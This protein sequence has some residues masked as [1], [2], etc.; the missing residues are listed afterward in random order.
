MYFVKA[1]FLLRKRYP[2]LI[3]NM[4][5]QEKSLYITFDDG[6][7]PIV[8]NEIRNVLRSYQ[9]KATFFCVGDNI[10]KNRDSFD[11]LLSDGH[12]IGNHTFNHVNGW[13]APLAD[14]IE[15]VEK[16]EALLGNKLFRPPYSKITGKQSRELIR[17]GY[18]IVMWDVI[19]G[20]FDTKL[21]PEKCLKNVLDHAENGSIVVFH[22]HEKA[23]PRLQYALPRALE[24]WISQGFT[25]KTL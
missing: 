7:I 10:S 8:T 23:W 11:Q 14:Y 9:A 1:P 19:S 4:N 18:R 2:D 15:N 13:Q 21:R 3:W 12:T 16:C 20:D 22:D 24:H 5:R 6:P 17:R 25:F